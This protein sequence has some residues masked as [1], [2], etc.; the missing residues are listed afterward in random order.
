MQTQE[1]E[2]IERL[3]H[4]QHP[5]HTVAD[6]A[7]PPQSSLW[8]GWRGPL[9]GALLAVIIVFAV[10]D[11]GHLLFPLRT[12]GTTRPIIIQVQNGTGDTGTTVASALAAS[13]QSLDL[14]CGQSAAVTLTNTASY[15]IHWTLDMP[16][17]GIVL[18]ANSPHSGGLAPG[19]HTVLQVVSL[20]QSTNAT[21]HF[22]ETR[23]SALDVN[24]RIMC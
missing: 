23:G 21:L 7:T 18:S 6:A 14:R 3:D 17:N 11:L 2:P 20:G 5:A 22:A 8:S 4:T 19:E 1:P 9:I 15:S 16:S 24:V 10:L 12:Q 13:P